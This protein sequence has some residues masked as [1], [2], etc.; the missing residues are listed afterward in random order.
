MLAIDPTPSNSFLLDMLLENQQKTTAVEKFAQLHDRLELPLQVRH[1]RDLLPTSRPATDEQYAFEVDLDGCSGCKACVTACHNLNGL[2]DGEVWRSVGLLH[3]GTTD[4]PVIQHVT[5][6]CHHCVEPACLQGCPV[7]AYEKDPITGIVK[8]LDD[9]CI[10]CQYCML[11]C[12]YDVPKYSKSKGIVRKCDMCS[13]RLAADEAPACVQSCPNQAIRIRIVSQQQVIEESESNVFLPGVPEPEYTL[14]TTIYKSE[15]V[16]PRNVLP[17]DYYSS[18][19]AHAHMPLIVM[20]VLT[21]MSVGA[22]VVEQLL[23]SELIT[24]AGVATTEHLRPVQ[25]VAALLLGFLGLFAAIFHLGRPM[26]A[27]RAIIG[28][29]TSWLSRE[30]LAF[31]LFAGFA[32]AYVVVACASYFGWNSGPTVEATLGALAGAAGLLAV[33]C[34]MMI[35]IDTRR[36]F[37]GPLFTVPKFFGTCLVLGVPIA[38]LI[39]LAAAACSADL[40]VEQIISSYGWQL[41]RALIVIACAKLIFEAMIFGSLRRPRHTSLKRTALLLKGELSMVMTARFVVGMLGGILLP[42][43]LLSERQLAPD[44][45]FQPLFIGIIALLMTGLCLAGEFIERYLFFTAVVA[46]KMPGTQ[47]T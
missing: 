38:L 41:C 2:E 39:S 24:L 26:L 19:P 15:R 47:A 12:P 37:W 34:S 28:L 16:L 9:Q 4:L 36:V 29:A 11:K 20:L 17:A 45:G 6:A 22:F 7:K 40:T 21:Q 25:L 43:I 1:Y 32:T 5:T 33:V 14:P 3:G 31:T 10:G 35:Y 42:L 8:H 46:P 13:D 44:G 27:H 23:Q 30:I 18:R